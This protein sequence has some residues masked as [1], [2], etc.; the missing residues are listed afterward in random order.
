MLS[1]L[2]VPAL[3]RPLGEHLVALLDPRP[4]DAC[5]CLP[6]GDGVMRAAL[7]ATGATCEEITEATADG[8]AQVV[9]SLFVPLTAET[10]GRLLRV[11]DPERG[12]LACAVSVDLPGGLRVGGALPDLPPG[13]RLDHLRDVAR[14][15]GAAHYA[16]ATGVD[17]GEALQPF[18]S[19]DGTLRIPVD[20]EVLRAGSP[21]RPDPH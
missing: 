17:A 6:D 15:D 4:G 13:V 3:L 9:A 20:V 5:A 19:V 21:E 1:R 2:L 12:R 16:A 14:F 11:L 10:L 8:T 7:A 18:T